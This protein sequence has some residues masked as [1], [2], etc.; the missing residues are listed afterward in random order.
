M[1]RLSSNQEKERREKIRVLLK[2]AG[3]GLFLGVICA[4]CIRH[5]LI[6][7]WNVET[8][9]M[10]PNYSPGTRIYVSR[11]V[12]RTN[13]YLGDPVLAKHPTQ[14]EKVVF[15]RISGKPG[16]TVQMKNKVLYRNQ[17]SEDNAGSGKGY[18][19]QF[20][21]KRGPFP[22]SFSGR[23]NGEPLILKDREYFLL[24]DNRDSCS[25]SRDFGPIPIENILGKIL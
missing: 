24:C 9:D 7:P 18:M 6:F 14:T 4:I 16:D 23:D 8:K 19:L 1:S 5:F 12:N 3:I 21:D 13:L 11:F 10:L 2:R 17:N 20:D 22:A 15:L 25:D